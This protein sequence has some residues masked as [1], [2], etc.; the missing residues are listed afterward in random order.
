MFFSAGFKVTYLGHID[1]GRHGDVRQIDR[2]ARMLL[3]PRLEGLQR[4]YKK[5]KQIV[6]FEIGEIGVKIVDFDSNEVNK[7]QSQT[8]Q[9]LLR[10]KRFF[11]VVNKRFQVILKHSYMEISSCASLSS[12]TDYFAYIAG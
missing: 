10:N 12:M 11:I 2:A 4:D 5:T 9:M 7:L 3:Y 8:K 1:V 6:F